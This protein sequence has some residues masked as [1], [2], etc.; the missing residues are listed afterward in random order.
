MTRAINQAGLDLIKSFE[1]CRLEAYL[2]TAE[3]RPTIGWGHTGP[4][5]AFGDVCTQDQADAWLRADLEWAERAVEECATVELTD[6]QFAA[7]VSI[8]F[9]IGAANFERSTLLRDLDAG[10]T[11]AAA[12]CFLAW[13][14][15]RG[16]VLPGLER[17]RAAERALF[18]TA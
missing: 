15:Q 4:D 14:R 7:L 11:D 6:N 16:A 18:L 8:A 13:D 3:D 9:N 5:V 2:P 1:T 10:E 12:A 17:R